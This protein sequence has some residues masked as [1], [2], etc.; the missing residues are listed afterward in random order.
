LSYIGPMFRPAVSIITPTG[1]R[2]ALLRLQHANVLRQ[3]VQDFE[4]LILDDSPE[5][6]SFF[7]GLNDPRIHYEHRPGPRLTIGA[8]RNLLIGRAASDIIIHLDDDDFHAA[9]Y[10]ATIA[11]PLTGGADVAKFSGFYV[12]SAPFRTLGYWDLSVPQSGLHHCISPAGVTTVNFGVVEP[13]GLK[14]VSLGFYLAYRKAVWERLPFADLNH[15]E[16]GDF[17][18]TARDAGFKLSMF[19]D[20]SGSSLY[21]LRHDNTSQSYPQYLLPDFLLTKIFGSEVLPM[22]GL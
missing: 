7:A 10:L 16:D 21:I 12:Y 5:P 1:R 6:S 3:T 13:E 20:S 19:A 8:K 17:V 2:E 22:I 18:K 14:N 4:W 9:H 15:G 11:A